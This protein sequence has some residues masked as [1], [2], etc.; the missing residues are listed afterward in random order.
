MSDRIETLK[1]LLSPS[2]IHSPGTPEYK[3]QSLPWSAHAEAHPKLVVTPNSLPSLQKVVKQLYSD[4]SIDFAVRNTGTGCASARDVILSMHGF[5]GFTFD[6]DAETATLGAGLDWSEAESLMAQ[7]APG[8]ALVGARCGW[9]GVA[10]GALVGGY[11]WLSHE[12]GLVSDPQNLL[13]VQIILGDG[14]VVWAGEEDPELL[15][16]MRGGGGNFGV[17]VALKMRARKYVSEIFAGLV[18]LPYERLAEVGKWAAGMVHKTPDPKQA[19]AI[20]NQGPGVGVPHQGRKPGI[21]VV[22]FDANGE[23]HARSKEVGFGAV[24][25]MEGL[26]EVACG[27]C[28]LDGMTKLAD[29]YRTY[30]GVNKFWG[31]APLVTDVDEG[32]IERSWEWYERSLEAAGELE[33]GSTVLFEFMQEGFF[34]SSGSHNAS[35]W[36]HSGRN[37][38]MQVVLGCE[39]G[40]AP[41][42]LEKVV[43]QRLSQVEA[44]IVGSDKATGRFHAGFLHEWNDFGLVYGDNLGKLKTLKQKYDPQNRFDKSVDLAGEGKRQ[45]KVM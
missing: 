3:T 27:M 5:K 33:Q 36:P 24:F 45:N 20:T 17:V 38:I 35:A 32:L 10:G 37:H 7:H 25:G 39:A 19:F 28:P 22:M 30:Q 31:S 15:W 23:E 21:A 42:G 26:Q 9:V 2:E 29:T 18:F 16:G 14:R 1:V 12:F 8:W 44:E 6:A 43:Q 4:T 34:N 41:E 13:D 11:S 40:N